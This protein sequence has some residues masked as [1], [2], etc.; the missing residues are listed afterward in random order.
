MNIAEA[1]FEPHH[2]FTVGGKA[3]MP[4]LDDA[5]MHRSD[6][7][8]VQAVTFGRQECVGS[9]LRRGGAARAERMLDSPE[10]EVEPG[11]RVRQ[12][13]W[14]QPVQVTQRTLQTDCRRVPRADRGKARLRTRNRGDG[15]LARTVIEH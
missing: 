7:N 2:R 5:G 8:L 10:A 15:D 3:E 12:A 13:V 1:L 9:A 6:R 11:S 4:G 14:L